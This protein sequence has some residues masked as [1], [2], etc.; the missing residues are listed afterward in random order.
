MG[1][2]RAV[3]QGSTEGIEQMRRGIGDVT[4]LGTLINHPMM[5]GELAEVLGRAGQHSEALAMLQQALRLSSEN[6]EQYWAAELCRI[7]GEVLLGQNLSAMRASEE[8]FAQ[9][10]DIAR[11][12]EARMLELRAATS[13]ARLWKDLGRRTEALELLAPIYQWFTEGHDTLDLRDAKSLL[14]ELG[15][16]TSTGRPVG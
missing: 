8:A 4:A 1:L 15:S 16:N 10:L 13:L 2:A 7:R 5:L 6:G 11:Q 14:G 3:G 9:A 12:Q